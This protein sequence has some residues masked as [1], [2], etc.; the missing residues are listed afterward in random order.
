MKTFV[1]NHT[2]TASIKRYPL[3]FDPAFAIVIP[4]HV[5]MPS[6]HAEEMW[7]ARTTAIG[8]G[9]S[10]THG[11]RFID[12][13]LLIS[14]DVLVN[15]SGKQYRIVVF[16]MEA[17]DIP[18]ASWCGNA[19]SGRVIDLDTSV[20]PAAAIVKRDNALP[21]VFKVATSATVTA[22]GTAVSDCIALTDGS[23]TLTSAA[24][25][26]EWTPASGVGEGLCGLAFN[27]DSAVTGSYT[28]TGAAQAISLGADC[29]LAFVW[30]TDGSGPVLIAPRGTNFVKAC[31]A[32]TALDTTVALMGGRLAFGGT[33]LNA[34]GVS[35]SYIG[36]KRRPATLTENR[37][38]AVSVSGRKAVYFQGRGTVGYVDFG[39]G[40]NLSGVMSITWTGSVPGDA[41][42]GDLT[43]SPLLLKA[44]AASGS[45][46]AGVASWGLIA[47]SRIDDDLHGWCGP[48]VVGVVTGRVSHIKPLT[49]S[50]WRTG[51]IAP[52][53]FH[54]HA[55]VHRGGGRWDYY[56]DGV[57]R[58]QRAEA[59]DSVVS[60]ALHRVTMGARWN[61]SAYQ[62]NGR[63]TS[64]GASVYSRALSSDEVRVLCEHE[65]QGAS[66]DVTSGLAERWT[67]SGLSGTTWAA[68]VDPANTGTLTGGAIAV[69]L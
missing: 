27:S 5:Q 44:A 58:K 9:A 63:M 14:T 56:L 34:N 48:H 22:D 47:V 62:N 60:S 61:G 25:V 68:T 65:L 67:G 37:A 59:T 2:G 20:R 11:C 29:E 41:P 69:D 57:L 17:G 39:T 53:G 45:T 49:T 6:I 12:R 26:N 64:L 18:V 40:L 35:Y 66:Q 32:S 46:T 7:G 21:A 50:T 30:R 4:L 15:D 33:S 54:H 24:H 28:G 8:P 51:V 42:T 10:V 43:D 36:L 13:T 16:G 52:A 38:P 3:P 23:L 19:Q 55:L 31:D 1:I